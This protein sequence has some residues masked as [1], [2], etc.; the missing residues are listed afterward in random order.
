MK[1]AAPERPSNQA[2]A[3]ENN[4]SLAALKAARDAQDAKWSYV[5][6]DQAAGSDQRMERNPSSY[7]K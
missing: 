3:A 6:A 1:C 5:A 2:L 4:K 7:R